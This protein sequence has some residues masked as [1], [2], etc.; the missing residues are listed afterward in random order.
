MNKQ[1]LIEQLREEI[2]Q[3]KQVEETLK[4][5]LDFEALLSELSARFVVVSPEDVDQEIEQALK[6]ILDFFQVERCGLGWADKDS[7]KFVHGVQSQE[8]PPMPINRRMPASMF[9][10]VY[11]KI[12]E[13]HEAVI[14]ES[15]RELPAEASTDK[16]SY[17]AMGTQACLNLPVFH[18]RSYVYCL[19]LHSVRS[20]RNWPEGYIPQLRVLGEILVNALERS[21]SAEEL[22]KRL[23]EIEALKHKLE[24][25][26]IYLQEEV[27]SLAEHSE[28]VGQSSAIKKVLAQAQ[29]VAQTDSTVLL[30]GETGTGK[31]LMARIIHNLSRRKD[32]PLVT[33][34]TASLPPTLIESELFGREKGAYTG[35][36]TRQIGRFELA[37]GSSLFL[38]EIG[39]LAP[40]LQVKLLRVLQEGRFER[41][42]SPK[43]IQ[44]NVRIIAA[45][46]RDLEEA[47]QQGKF[48]EDL[49][50][51]LAVFPIHIPPLRER[52]EDISPMVEFFVREFAEKMG[53]RIRNIPR[54][55]IEDL[56]RYPWPGNV[57]ELRNVIER[58]VIVSSGDTLNIELPQRNKGKTSRITTL[59]EAEHDHITEVLK[60]TGWRI[61]GPGGAAELLGLKPSNL[62]ATMSRLGIPTKRQKDTILT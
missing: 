39:E 7:W 25:E 11:K 17:E 52:T 32:R 45:T 56:R 13:R 10:W 59:K 1:A 9:P 35:A 26:N 42:G 58:A 30:L 41:L 50:Y 6:Q 49:Y 46:N 53:K 51:R 24:T 16:Q 48:R 20:E 31:E 47:V 15:L 18:S 61:K 22:N 23:R 27:K 5:R 36:A 40:E 55:A 2:I 44:S 54:K 38:D 60:K 21:R 37:N 34:N 33:V 43:S 57:R 8:V 62:Y 3:R 4:D 19:I 29:Q 28:I 12:V 14:F